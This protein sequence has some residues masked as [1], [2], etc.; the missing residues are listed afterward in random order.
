MLQRFLR[1]PAVMQITG[2]C[3]STIYDR[4]D[5]GSFPR[6]VSPGKLA[7]GWLEGEIQ[8][9]CK[10]RISERAAG[11]RAKTNGWEPGIK[12]RIEHAFK[13]PVTVVDDVPIPSTDRWRTE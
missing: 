12:R 5:E 11:V 13:T 9:W 7:V 6:P 3:R 8:D 4:I 10:A 2:L 1:L